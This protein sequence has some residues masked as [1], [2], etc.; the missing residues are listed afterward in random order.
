MLIMDIIFVLS[1]GAMIKR[2]NH[3]VRV[4]LSTKL[5]IMKKFKEI[6]D[7]K[8]IKLTEETNHS[9]RYLDSEDFLEAQKEEFEIARKELNAVESE[10]REVLKSEKKLSKMDEIQVL[11][12]LL[13]DVNESLRNS[14]IAYNADILGYNYWVRFGPW[15]Y[16]FLLF[17]IKLKKTI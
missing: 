17:R 15:R 14:T 1:F 5:D 8:K 10:I 16:I 3:G 6:F 4:A 12:T 11:L 7:E 9:I 13:N 2:D